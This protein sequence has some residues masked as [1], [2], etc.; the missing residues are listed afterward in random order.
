MA[1]IAFRDYERL[2]HKMAND[3]YRKLMASGVRVER[4]D[5]F[6]ELA[7]VFVHASKKF[8]ANRGFKFTT[9]YCMAC[10]NHIVRLIQAR[11]RLSAPPEMVSL[12]STGDGSLAETIPDESENVEQ[13]MVRVA[14]LQTRMDSL[15][16]LTRSVVQAIESNQ[17]ELM[18]CLNGVRARVEY[19][20]Q[21]GII[22]PAPRKL[23]IGIIA[24]A[25]GL[26]R[27]QVHQVHNEIHNVLFG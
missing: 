22:E 15:S 13:A 25:L 24:T 1:D 4:E 7:E 26:S 14:D 2:V 6:Q 11:Y 8:D 19:G 5:L 3:G 10:H 16:K 9:Y 17:E 21:R 20:K 23:G 27:D 12:D 18:R